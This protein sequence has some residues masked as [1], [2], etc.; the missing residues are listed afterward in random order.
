MNLEIQNAVEEHCSG[1]ITARQ[2]YDTIKSM[3]YYL[4]KMGIDNSLLE[5]DQGGQGGTGNVRHNH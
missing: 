5:T 2:F 4:E 3:I 1:R